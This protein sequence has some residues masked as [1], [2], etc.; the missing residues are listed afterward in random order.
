LSLIFCKVHNRTEI[1]NAISSAVSSEKSVDSPIPVEK[2][3]VSED[4]HSIHIHL[5]A[6]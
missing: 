6:A 3:I 2:N 5:Q 4:S 1:D